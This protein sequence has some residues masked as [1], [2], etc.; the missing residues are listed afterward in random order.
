MKIYSLAAS[1]LL[2]FIGF[3]QNSYYFSEPLPSE[4]NSV[5]HVDS[6]NYGT[7]EAKN[8]SIA[9]EFSA[10]GVT[11]I[12]T[13]VSSVSREMVRES[14]QY[15]VRDGYIHG[16]IAND[17]LPCVLEGE[18]YY[19]GIRNRDVFVG[20]GSSNVLTKT[21]VPGTYIINVRENGNYTPM[22][23]EFNRKTVSISNFDYEGNIGNEF[24]YITEQKTIKTE[25]Q[26]L[27]ILSPT[28]SE[29]GEML[30]HNVFTQPFVLKR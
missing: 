1:V 8:G 23:F 25:F 2:S 7:Y 15:S 22:L 14:S 18:Y 6:K 5:E 10:N 16:V 4:G 29:Y 21:N 27:I 26:N 13:I 11:I 20:A 30:T 19:F 28:V 24:G 12:T 17:S 3:S 9:Y